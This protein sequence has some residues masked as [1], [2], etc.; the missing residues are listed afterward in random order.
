VSSERPKLSDTTPRAIT[1]WDT[2]TGRVV[3]LT[4]ERSWS[5][6]LSEAEVFTGPASDVLALAK[7]DQ[8]RATD[9]YF[10]QV[11]PAG[12][13]AGREIL[14]ETIRLNGPT[15]HPDFQRGARPT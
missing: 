4:R 14:R 10:M 2:L 9:P 7:A 15:C 11:T 6:D 12:E 8:T 1:G 13:V 3:Y 5:P